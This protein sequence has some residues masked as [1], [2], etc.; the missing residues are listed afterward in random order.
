MKSK[1]ISFEATS[2]KSFFLDE[3]DFLIL[4]S[5]LE[6]FRSAFGCNFR[7]ELANRVQEES[8]PE[9]IIRYEI[10]IIIHSESLYDLTQVEQAFQ[11]MFRLRGI[12]CFVFLI[13]QI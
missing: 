2:S 3:D 4:E 1:F 12:S 5:A 6:S 11:T 8:L 9:G 7:W 13:Q 10:S